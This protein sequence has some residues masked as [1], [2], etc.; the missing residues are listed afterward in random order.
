MEKPKQ[1]AIE[2]PVFYLG[3]DPDVSKSGVCL[4]DSK[5]KVIQEL[6]CMT[7]P[8]LLDFLMSLKLHHATKLKVVIE[9]GWLNKSNWHSKFN[10]SHAFNAKIGERTGANFEVGK[11]L[12]EMCEHYGIDAILAKPKRSKINAKDFSKITKYTKRTNQE[13]R[14]ACMMVFGF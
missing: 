10:A 14:D 6:T 8:V 11:K 13:M 7:F 3:I 1:I 2:K 4:W 5:S 12:F 9:A